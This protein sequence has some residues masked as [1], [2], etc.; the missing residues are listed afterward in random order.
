MQHQSHL[1]AEFRASR[2]LAPLTQALIP[3]SGPCPGSPCLPPNPGR[4]QSWRGHKRN[5]TGHFDHRGWFGPW[6]S[7]APPWSLEGWGGVGALAETQPRSRSCPPTGPWAQ[8]GRPRGPKWVLL[9]QLGPS[10][11]ARSAVGQ[12]RGWAPSKG[13]QRDT[14]SS[15]LKGS[16]SPG[17][18]WRLGLRDAIDHRTFLTLGPG[19]ATS[20]PMQRAGPTACDVGYGAV[21]IRG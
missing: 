6:P 18:L 4:A 16:S 2:G 13:A 10:F 19:P 21:L 7:P 1:E 5:S 3:A 17:K 14:P 20:W 11:C 9:T 12:S 8:P 15:F